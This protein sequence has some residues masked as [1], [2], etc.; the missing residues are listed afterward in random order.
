V[1]TNNAYRRFG[2]TL[3]AERLAPTG[4]QASLFEG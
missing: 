1:A 4:P 2:Y 3:P